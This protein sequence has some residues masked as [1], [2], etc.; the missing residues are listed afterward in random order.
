MSGVGL[1]IGSHLRAHWKG[2]AGLALIVGVA[3]APVLTAAA[4]AR[5]TAT[6]VDRYTHAALARDVRLEVNDPSVSEAVSSE[7]EALDQVVASGRLDMYPISPRNIADNADG[8]FMIVASP[9]GG[10]GRRVDRG[11][12]LRGRFA[13]PTAPLEVVLNERMWRT[14]GLGVGDRLEV[15]TLTNADLRS[16][17]GLSQN[18]AFSG[19]NG[20]VLSLLV[21]GVV[22]LPD[23]LAGDDT[24]IAVGTPAFVAAHR[25]AVA[26]FPGGL[27]ARLAR[28][29]RDLP[30]VQAVVSRLAPAEAEVRLL[31]AEDEFYRSAQATTKV[32]SNALWL[33]VLVAGGA[34]AVAVGGAMSRHLSAE[35]RP[36]PTL[37][38]LGLG[39]RERTIASGVPSLLAVAA[40]AGL[41]VGG[42]IAA[43]PLMPL[44]LARRA[45]PSPGIDVDPL[46]AVVSVAVIVMAA[47]TWLLVLSRRLGQVGVPV[48]GARPQPS[49]FAAVGW[50]LGPAARLGLAQGLERGAGLGAVPVRA[51]LAASLLAVAGVAATSTVV[52]SMDALVEDPRRYGWA[53]SARM[54]V[55]DELD[56]LAREPGLA[57]GLLHNQAV[58]LRGLHMTGYALEAIR[59]EMAPV[60]RDGSVPVAAD[61]IALG[62]KT[63]RELGV[64]VGD[65]VDAVTREGATVTLRV[66]GT[67][68]LPPVDHPDPG[69]G[70]LFTAEGLR[71]VE[72]SDGV[73]ALVVRYPD[74]ADPLR[75][76]ELLRTS[77]GLE[78]NAESY[79]H[80]P[81][82]LINLERARG[83]VVVLGA[84]FVVLGAF[85]VGHALVVAARRRR[86]EIAVLQALGLVRR[87]V[88]ALFAWHAAATA[89]L[90]VAIGLPVG[91]VAGRAI[92]Q[93]MIGDFGLI[94]HPTL[95]TA[96][97]VAVVPASLLVA[98]ALGWLPGRR[99]ARLRASALRTE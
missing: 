8:F 78:L 84:F 80:V 6:A 33:F 69:Q 66:V 25:D 62:A 61:E 11:L 50:R 82:N 49:R 9:D 42:S 5:R 90:G 68:V 29:S 85:S 83:I 21:A 74:G 71:R 2:L 27:A 75:Y 64:R 19:F 36:N 41:A 58:E 22:R 56:G 47:A 26:G 18:E 77:H 4:G 16:M 81:G 52:R 34:G 73:T 28:G 48:T 87:Q 14:T 1:V 46:V 31:A 88:R 30:A 63:A 60:L 20:P 13:D 57:F 17:L 94:D 39:S 51:A 40:G 70:A 86:Q 59:G 91:I 43:S 96:A 92:W 24:L 79:P 53:W 55:P 76:E 44:G 67:V 38:A 32:L 95:H 54:G 72:R 37:R 97:L 93:L 12:L 99:A 10:W 89:V 65:A 7:V 15:S 3:G 23:D 45:E 35:V 98:V